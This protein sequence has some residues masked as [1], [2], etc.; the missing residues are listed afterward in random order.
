MYLPESHVEAA[1]RS[2]RVVFAELRRAPGVPLGSEA[3]AFEGMR[4][5]FVVF[6]LGPL[7]VV[8]V[9]VWWPLLFA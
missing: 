2:L 7:A 6:V 9:A 1:A 3:G 4:P 8:A 5:A